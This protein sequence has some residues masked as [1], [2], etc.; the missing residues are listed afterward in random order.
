[1]LAVI[2]FFLEDLD[3]NSINN[4]TD[5]ELWS[6]QLASWIF[7]NDQNWQTLFKERFVIVH[8]NAFNYLCESGTEVNARIRI[9]DDTK[10]VQKGALWYE[11]CLPAETILAGIAT[12]DR[13]FGSKTIAASVIMDTCCTESICCQMGGNSTVGKGQV[14]MRFKEL[15]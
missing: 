13:V 15:K 2:L 14:I 9:Q 11:E 10:V 1:M 6:N 3:F 8:D 5:T 12:C 4:N 7:S